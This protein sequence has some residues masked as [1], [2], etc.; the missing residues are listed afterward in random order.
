[1][2]GVRLKEA[3]AG[4]QSGGFVGGYRRLL[5]RQGSLGESVKASVLK[6]LFHLPWALQ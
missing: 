1:M 6:S 5:P 2:A 4:G 3:F